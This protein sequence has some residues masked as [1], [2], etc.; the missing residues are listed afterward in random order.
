MVEFMIVTE[1]LLKIQASWYVKTCR[2]VKICLVF[3]EGRSVHPPT[4]T[5]GLSDEGDVTSL[6][7][8]QD[9]FKKSTLLGVPAHLNNG[10][11]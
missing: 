5:T 11:G 2:F 9:C 8:L 3:G 4:W 1:A 10:D 6:R 7:N